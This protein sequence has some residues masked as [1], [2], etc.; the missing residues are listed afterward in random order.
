MTYA[1][2]AQPVRPCLHASHP[3]APTALL[4]LAIDDSPPARTIIEI[5]LRLLIG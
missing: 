1:A 4:V 5:P 3:V 2:L